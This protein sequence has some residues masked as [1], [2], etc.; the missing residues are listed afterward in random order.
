MPLVQA[1]TVAPA[2][3]RAGGPSAASMPD[4]TLVE[5]T[6]EAF[7]DKGGHQVMDFRQCRLPALLLMQQINTHQ[8]SSL[9]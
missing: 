6:L 1:D 7:V 3:Y 9:Q 2:P 4:L 5:L 8:L